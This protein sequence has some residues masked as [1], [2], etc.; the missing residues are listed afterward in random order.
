MKFIWIKEKKNYENWANNIY[1]LKT[2][3]HRTYAFSSKISAYITY[4]KKNGVEK[5]KIIII[6]K[7]KSTNC[8]KEK[9]IHVT[10]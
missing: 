10:A 6:I 7:K 8:Q 2:F 9:L 4:R 3:Y 5:V 1:L